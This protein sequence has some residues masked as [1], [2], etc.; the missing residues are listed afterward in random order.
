MM[1]LIKAVCVMFG[2]ILG[3]A[4]GY[5]T[6]NLNPEY[7]NALGS[8]TDIKLAAIMGGLGYLI[9]SIVL[10]ELSEW[11][12]LWKEKIG[13]HTAL[14]GAL[15]AVIGLV[16]SN[17]FIL[18]PM[19]FLFNLEE[20][21]EKLGDFAYV[22]PMFKVFIPLFVNLLGLYVGISVLVKNHREMISFI[23][24]FFGG[25][26]TSSASTILLLDSSVII[27]GRILDIFKTGFLGGQ[28]LVPRF[29]LSELQL[30]ADSSDE[31][32]RTR[33]RRGLDILNSLISTSSGAVAVYQKDFENIKE[34]DAKLVELAK[35]LG[36]SIVTND[37]NLNKVAEIEGVKV[38]NVNDLANAI[39]PM[40]IPG[41]KLVLAIVK[42]G[43]DPDQGVGY[44]NDGTMVVVDGAGSLIGQQTNV[45]VKSVLQTSA[46]RMIFAEIMDRSA[47]KTENPSNQE[48]GL[49]NEKENS[50]GRNSRDGSDS[51]N[52][53]K[54]R[55][56]PR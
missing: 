42:E 30:I 26:D 49:E 48:R 34:V 31:M 6:G 37:F 40:F 19:M 2:T 15:G 18:L 10:R 20:L 21:R 54:Y 3:V 13:I 29:V 12:T 55:R 4:T 17:L 8:N 41:D 32:K 11:F 5:V 27:D 51:V 50:R 35:F 43:K 39:K 52:K 16:I 46:G 24:N 56:K 1:A 7:I 23:A 14:V 38:L 47:R 45:N 53:Q 33:G 36:G 9:F 25:R 44:M 28:I 22:I